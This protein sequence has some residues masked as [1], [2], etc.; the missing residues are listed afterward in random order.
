MLANTQNLNDFETLS[1]KLENKY[2]GLISRQDAATE[3]GLHLETVKRW[4]R[5]GRLRCVRLSRRA[6]K[7]EPS[8]LARLIVDCRA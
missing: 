2:G 4:S 6:I 8:E 1:Q 5:S 3:L 7:I